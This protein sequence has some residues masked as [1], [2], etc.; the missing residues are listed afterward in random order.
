MAYMALFPIGETM[1]V[2]LFVYRDMEDP[3]LQTFRRAPE[4]ALLTLMPDL[5]RH[6]GEF[7][8]ASFV[9]IRPV[10]LVVTTGHLQPGIVLAG[11]AFGTS[12]PAAGT[13]SNKEFTDV[14]RLCNVY[15]PAWLETP[16]MGAEKIRQFYDDPEKKATD[17]F[18]LN[19]AFWLKAIST[20][21]GLV[22]RAKRQAR[23]LG[24]FGVGLLRRL[25]ESLRHRMPHGIK[26]HEVGGRAGL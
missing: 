21:P 25:R 3:W 2:N 13:G 23:F 10:D 17:A 6:I 11:D 5:K 20:E 12:C 24:H 22:W 1:R 16:G 4:E 26:V 8:V 14:E 9:K 15:V 18:S 19:K 7:K